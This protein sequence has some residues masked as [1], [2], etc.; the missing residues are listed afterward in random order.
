MLKQLR[1]LEKFRLSEEEVLVEA[2][3]E[4]PD[5]EEATCEVEMLLISLSRELLMELRVLPIEP[6]FPFLP[7][8][9]R[10]QAPR[11]YLSTFSKIS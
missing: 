11:R 9:G 4:L 8:R 6:I 7:L 1:D 3:A 2:A 10:K 5:V